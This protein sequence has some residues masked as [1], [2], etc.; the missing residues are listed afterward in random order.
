MAEKPRSRK[1]SRQ[2]ATSSAQVAPKCSGSGGPL[3][4]ARAWAHGVACAQQQLLQQQQR[5]NWSS[6]RCATMARRGPGAKGG[7]AGA[8]GGARANLSRA[9]PEAAPRGPGGRRAGGSEPGA[10]PTGTGTETATGTGTGGVGDGAE[11]PR[12]SIFTPGTESVIQATRRGDAQVAPRLDRCHRH[13]HHLRGPERRRRCHLEAGRPPR[14]RRRRG[15]GLAAWRCARIAV[16]GGARARAPQPRALRAG[17]GAKGPRGRP[18]PR[19]RTKPRQ[20]GRPRRGR[21]AWPCAR[22]G[23]PEAEAEA[24]AASPWG[25]TAAAGRSIPHPLL[26]PGSLAAHRGCPG[27]RSPAWPLTFGGGGSGVAH[28]TLVYAKGR[29]EWEEGCPSPPKRQLSPSSSPPGAGPQ[30]ARWIPCTPV[31]LDEQKWLSAMSLFIR[32]SLQSLGLDTGR[33]LGC[34]S[35]GKGKDCFLGVF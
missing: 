26:E 23:V 6:R 8:T 21:R 35:G 24:A 17:P 25:P 32:G 1:D 28:E 14:P 10:D 3:Q 2:Q 27:G 30:G 29:A 16:P 33:V 5:P 18:P 9:S 22:M 20:D 12:W 11:P 19:R 31:G 4:G 15:P 34:R 13:R 7:G